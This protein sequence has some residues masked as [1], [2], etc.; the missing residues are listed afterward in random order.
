MTPIKVTPL[1]G[2]V[3]V[4]TGTGDYSLG[5]AMPAPNRSLQSVLAD[6]DKF[7]Y[8]CRDG[9]NFETGVGTYHAAGGGTVT[10]TSVGFSSNGSNTAFNWT[11]G[12]TRTLF[13]DYGYGFLLLDNNLS[14]LPNPQTSRA[15][16]GLPTNIDLTS[17]NSIVPLTDSSGR[18]PAGINVSL[19]T[20]FPA[21]T[22]SIPSGT[23]LGGFFQA[24]A[25]SGWT[26]ITTYD[27]C[28]I[29]IANNIGTT[30]GGP[31]NGGTF[32]AGGWDPTSGVTVTGTAISIAQ[33]PAH[34]HSTAFVSQT[35]GT[36]YASGTSIP[37]PP[38]TGGST[39]ADTAST[40]GGATHT[41]TLTNAQ[42]WRPPTLKT[43]LCSKN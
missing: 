23:A 13:I 31:F 24:A 1:V 33:M 40:G 41:H 34:V 27:D 30:G 28:L 19:C 14:D 43:L 4:T 2:S 26:R 6:G 16:L 32:V 18:L 38:S 7:P 12:G 39:G 5:A 10:R 42:S 20:G 21:A 8:T 11:G 3:T 36:V 35:F 25:P 22:A 29:G 17:V 37:A 9:V 15:N